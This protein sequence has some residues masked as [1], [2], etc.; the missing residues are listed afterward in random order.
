MKNE[1]TKQTQ[2][3]KAEMFERTARRDR[4]F[5]NN[6]V[7]MQGLGLAPLIVADTSLKNAVMLSV[8]VILLLMPT[9]VIA[10]TL[11]RFIHFRFRG[12]VYALTSAS[13]YIG[14]FWVMNRLFPAADIALLG[15]YLPLLVVDPIVLKRYERP[16]REHLDAA[17]QK[18]I[19]T[20]LGYA[21][22]LLI[23]GAVREMLGAGTL[24]GMTISKMP[25]FPIAK[26]P[27]GGFMVLALIMALWRGAVFSFK[28]QINMGGKL[29]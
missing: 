6:P 24:Y 12:L 9:R 22:T 4:I 3:N 14:V 7:I 15:L 18:G 29:E 19:I 23:V 5:L 28:K 2:E 8:A 13:A 10:A 20:A 11:S 26:L 27:A 16:Q 17:F 1:N 25:L 21:L